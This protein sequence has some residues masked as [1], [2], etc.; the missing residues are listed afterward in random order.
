QANAQLQHVATHDALTGLPNRL[1]LADRL[2]QA[3]ARAE[4]RGQRFAL[5][6]V[7]LDR[8]KSINDSLGHLAGDELLKEVARRLTRVLRKADTLARLGGDEFVLLLNE[9]DNPHDA[10]AVAAKVL[11]DFAQPVVISGLDLHISASLGISVSP[12]D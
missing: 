3:I 2:D 5:I 4:R 8:F 1:L 11:A 6:V 10:E 9:I 7:D 12:D